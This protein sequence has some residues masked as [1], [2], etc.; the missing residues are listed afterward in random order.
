MLS[1]A[2]GGPD[3][4]RRLVDAPF[5]RSAGTAREEDGMATAAGTQPRSDE[6]TQAAG[7]PVAESGD[8]RCACGMTYRYAR[9]R[10][11]VTFWPQNSLRGFRA[12][13]VAAPECIRCG[14][15]LSA[16]GRAAA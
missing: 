12:T 13:P 16:P 4:E 9:R 10:A 15:R 5:L 2:R 8:V 3:E 6:T 14:R 11:G 7:L 1:E